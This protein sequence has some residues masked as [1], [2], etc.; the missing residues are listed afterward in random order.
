MN[1]PFVGEVFVDGVSK[2]AVDDVIGA[3]FLV[4]VAIWLSGSGPME[5]P[6]DDPKMAESSFSDSG[7]PGVSGDNVVDAFISS[8]RRY[9]PD[10]GADRDP[11]PPP[12]PFPLTVA[13]FPA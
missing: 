11:L 4:V 8:A 10:V 13:S 9:L 6:V 3:T 12:V 5:D 7:V 2:E 1:R